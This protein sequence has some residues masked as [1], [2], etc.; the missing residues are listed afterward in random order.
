MATPLVLYSTITRLADSLGQKYYN[1]QHYVWCAPHDQ[2]DRN[3]LRNPPSSD[4][5]SIYWRFYRDIS[6]GDGHSPYIEANRSG[7]L[8]GASVKEK[9]GV[10]DRPTRERIATMVTQAPLQDFFPLF[11]V[12]PYA[13]VSSFV[14]AA[15]IA[16][17]ARATSDEYIIEQLPRA[18]FDVLE[19]HG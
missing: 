17:V 8:V 11:L 9:R 16:I 7:L 6:D 15:D 10:I 13:S 3:A 4:P 5:L 19:L 14:R 12:I 1:G 18:Y 2:A